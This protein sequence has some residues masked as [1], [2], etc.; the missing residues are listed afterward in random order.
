MSIEI[1]K[2]KAFN[3]E[4]KKSLH[5]LKQENQ[6]LQANLDASINMNVETEAIKRECVEK[7][8]GF[9]DQVAVLNRELELIKGLSTDRFPGLNPTLNNPCASQWP[10]RWAKEHKGKVSE[11]MR[12]T[13]YACNC[14][15]RHCHSAWISTIFQH[16]VHVDTVALAN[17]VASTPTR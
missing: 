2:L 16:I 7:N 15:F 12:W 11:M 5:N 8:K 4:H 9:R 17:D 13:L 1:E 3:V 10:S 14:T 6:N